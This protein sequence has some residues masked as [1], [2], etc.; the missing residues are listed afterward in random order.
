MT[1]LCV[2]FM[3]LYSCIISKQNLIVPVVCNLQQSSLLHVGLEVLKL[4]GT[5]DECV[6]GCS[7]GWGT[8]IILP[9]YKVRKEIFRVEKRK[10]MNNKLSQKFK[11]YQFYEINVIMVI[12][13]ERTK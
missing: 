1:N 2:M 4:Y 7:C 13:E 8:T 9:D 10:I 12:K 6:W 11:V 5:S 3:H